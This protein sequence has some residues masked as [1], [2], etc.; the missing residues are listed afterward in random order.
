MLVYLPTKFFS[1]LVVF[2]TSRVSIWFF[3]SFKFSATILNL[4]FI[5]SK[6]AGVATLIFDCGNSTVNVSPTWQAFNTH[7]LDIF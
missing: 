1:S 5:S 3:V 6:V 2:F 4:D 7:L